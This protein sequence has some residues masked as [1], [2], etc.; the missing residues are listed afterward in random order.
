[1]ALKP[2]T[3]RKTPGRW[4]CWT[5]EGNNKEANHSKSKGTS[6]CWQISYFPWWLLATD[7]HSTLSPIPSS[8]C[9]QVMSN[10]IHQ[11]PETK[12]LESEWDLK[13]VIECPRYTYDICTSI[14]NHDKALFHPIQAGLHATARVVATCG[15]N[16]TNVEWSK[17]FT[18]HL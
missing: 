2:I 3:K 9:S 13:I 4:K 5:L 7:V 16:S 1:M 11:F 14:G 15:Q 18:A 8:F 12:K 17:C 6:A 10:H